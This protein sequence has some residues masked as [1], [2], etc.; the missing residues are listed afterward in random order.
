MNKPFSNKTF[1]YWL[2]GNEAFMEDASRFQSFAS[3]AV[4]DKNAS[5]HRRTDV[6]GV[7]ADEGAWFSFIKKQKLEEGKKAPER[8][9]RRE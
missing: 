5:N 3:K 8:N 1:T 7:E 9:K 6:P 2:I 4:K